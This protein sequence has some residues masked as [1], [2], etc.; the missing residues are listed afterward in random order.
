MNQNYTVELAKESHVREIPGIEQAAAAMFSES[1][2]P[3]ELRYLVSDVKTLVEAQRE[4]RLWAALDG[5]RTLV[6]F[7]M[8]GIVGGLAHLEEMDVHPEHSRQGIGGRLLDAVTTWAGDNGYSGM[9]L[10]TFRHLPWN[11]P[12]Y[13]RYGFI[14]LDERHNSDDLRQLLR[15]EAEAGIEPRKRVAMLYDISGG[16]GS[17]AADQRA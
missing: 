2:L 10:I 12:F 3:I 14:Q 7:A 8:V 16:S 4:G 17:A 1:D 5:D 9:T 11:A 15:E 13:E 6:G